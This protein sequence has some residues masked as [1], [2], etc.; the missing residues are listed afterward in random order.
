M[1]KSIPLR[2]QNLIRQHAYILKKLASSSPSVRKKILINAPDPL[3]KAINAII[4]LIIRNIIELP[5]KYKQNINRNKKLIKRVGN[6]KNIK[7]LRKQVQNLNQQG[8]LFPLI[9]AAIPAITSF[10]GKLF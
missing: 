9:A 7:L 5:R 4:R 8:G 2:D 1:P 6:L 3:F 10:L